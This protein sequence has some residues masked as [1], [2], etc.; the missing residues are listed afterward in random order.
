MAKAAKVGISHFDLLFVY[1]NKTSAEGFR[2]HVPKIFDIAKHLSRGPTSLRC[3]KT[4]FCLCMRR[5]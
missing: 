1:V 4:L 5:S 3:L 2:K